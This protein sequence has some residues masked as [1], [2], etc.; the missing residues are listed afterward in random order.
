MR[1]IIPKI[2][3]KRKFIKLEPR[4]PLKKVVLLIVYKIEIND[5]FSHRNTRVT[6]LWSHDLL[7]NIL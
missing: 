2:H 5:N 6:K 1:L 4:T 3:L 7:D